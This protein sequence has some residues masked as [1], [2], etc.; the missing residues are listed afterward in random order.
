[1]AAVF[2]Q[3]P[4]VKRAA[5]ALLLAAS[6]AGAQDVVLSGRMGD[7]ALLVIDGQPYT[8]AVGQTVAGVKL[9]GWAGDQAQ[10]EHRGKTFTLSVG[11]TPVRMGAG[12]PRSGGE[13]REIVLTAG[14]GGHFSTAGT[15]NGKQ[16]RFLVDT[17]ATMVSIGKDDA[18]RLGLDLSNARRG[19]TQTANGPVQVALITLSSVRVGDVELSNVGAVVLPQPMPV[20]LL[21]NSFLSR[22]QMKRENDVMRLELR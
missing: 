3:L 22:L 15:I 16:V 1:M 5:A 7:R 4:R 2:Q 20:V 11:A 17:G 14:P 21:G 9:R 13:G 8:T 10:I 6:A 12:A 19:A 18:E